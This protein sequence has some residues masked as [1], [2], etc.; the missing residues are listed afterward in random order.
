MSLLCLDSNPKNSQVI[1]V[2][3]LELFL[4]KQRQSQC[5]EYFILVQIS[6]EFSN[7]FSNEFD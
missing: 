2:G 1:Q 3:F 4:K 5:I 7:K 6:I